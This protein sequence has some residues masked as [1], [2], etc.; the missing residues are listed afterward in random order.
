MLFIPQ[1]IV[2]LSI[3]LI[4]VIHEAIIYMYETL[5]RQIQDTIKPLIV[6]A[7]LYHDETARGKNKK[8]LAVES[9]TDNKLMLEPQSLV[10]QLEHFYKQFIFFGLQ[11]CYVEQI[12]QQVFY[13]ICAVALNN[14]ML[15]RDLCT[16]KTGMKL[17]FNVGCLE[18]WIKQ[19]KM[20]LACGF[21]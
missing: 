15:R 6:P 7:I 5:V 18:S 17:K 9:A 21:F 2:N 16:W 4:K 1:L 19:K 12:F 10:D 20:V 3:S 13:F 8:A 14:L 11:N